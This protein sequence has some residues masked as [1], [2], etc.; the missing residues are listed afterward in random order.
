MD[1]DAYRRVIETNPALSPV[2]LQGRA[3]IAPL[4]RKAPHED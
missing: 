3:A 1:G 4:R 2:G